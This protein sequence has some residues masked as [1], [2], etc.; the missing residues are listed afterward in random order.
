MQPCSCVTGG[1]NTGRPN[2]LPVFDVTKQLILVEY[3]KSDGTVNGI[4][5]GD[6]TNGVLTQTFLNDWVKN[7]D[8]KLRAYP[9]PELKNPT[10]ERGDD[11]MEEFED[12]SSIFIQD[13]SRNFEAMIVKGDPILLGNLQAWRC[14]K[15]GVYFIDK[16]GNLIGKNNREGYLDP[17]LIADE[18]FSI[19]LIKGTDTTKQKLR[20]KFQVS[21]LEDDANLMQLEASMITANL[22]GVGGLIDVYATEVTDITT[23]GFKV[24]LDTQFGGFTSKQPAEGL[25]TAD[26]LC[27]NVTDSALV[28]ITSATE[29][30]AIDGNY[31]FVITP[32]QTASDQLLITNKAGTLD[33]SYDIVSFNVTI[34]S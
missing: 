34:P 14:L 1:A 26:F 28:T 22:L 21:Q 30:A 2:C 25:E 31:T 19:G 5:E 27:Y 18:S 10:D 17:I 3:Y 29:S 6:L 24:Q 12:G 32:A 7:S 13:G 23:T 33:K 9:T 20:L 4:A 8:P 16:S 11:I 15:F